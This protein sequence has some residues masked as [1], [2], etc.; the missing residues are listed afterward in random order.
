MNTAPVFLFVEPYPNFRVR[1]RIWLKQVVINPTILIATNG[2]EAL[3]LT[4]QEQPSHI[5]IEME[6]PDLPGVEVIQQM[7]Q[8][9]PDARIVATGWSESRFFLN[10]AQSAG[11]NGFIRKPTL[12]SGLLD[13]WE[14]PPELRKDNG[15]ASTR[16]DP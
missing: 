16:S 2:V 5:L 15:Q 8:I 3:S 6:L 4:Q 13:L 1:L 7:R 12:P 9:L 10:E 11:A 14:I